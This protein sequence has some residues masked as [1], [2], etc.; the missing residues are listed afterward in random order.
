MDDEEED[1]EE[2]HDTLEETSREV[3]EI[4]RAPR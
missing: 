2:E 4:F 3:S 1:D